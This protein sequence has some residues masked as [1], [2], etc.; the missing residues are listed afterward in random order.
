MLTVWSPDFALL[1]SNISLGLLT[2]PSLLESR[3]KSLILASAASSCLVFSSSTFPVKRFNLLPPLASGTGSALRVG[4]GLAAAA[5]G[6]GTISADG[7]TAADGTFEMRAAGA[8]ATAAAA[9]D[10]PPCTVA[11][12]GE[13][14]ATAADF[15]SP[16]IVPPG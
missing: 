16:G 6:S 4:G 1:G 9:P 14:A 10:A 3:D 5:T 2:P 15:F 8:G 11:L 13:A 12:D 7:T